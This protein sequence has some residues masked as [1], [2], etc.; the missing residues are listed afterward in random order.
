MHII[1][2]QVTGFDQVILGN[3]VL[4][5]ACILTLKYD[6]ADSRTARAASVVL[7]C[8]GA[9]RGPLHEGC[10]TRVAPRGLLHEDRSMEGVADLFFILT[11]A[12]Y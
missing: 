6:A 9:P 8:V 5:D 2:L 10:S 1:I 4:S 12:Q 11:C 3:G 7:K